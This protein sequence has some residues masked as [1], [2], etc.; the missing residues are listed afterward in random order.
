[1]LNKL[2]GKA[3]VACDH[4]N[5]HMKALLQNPSHNNTTTNH[6]DNNIEMTVLNGAL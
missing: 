2:H 4:D 1:M 5:K 3:N 6:K